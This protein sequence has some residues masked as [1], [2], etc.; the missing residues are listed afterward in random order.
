ML[1]PD[2]RL[3]PDIPRASRTC[4]AAKPSHP[5]G[6]TS[7]LCS[8]LLHKFPGSTPASS[9]TRS[10]RPRSASGTAR[11]TVE[12]GWSRAVLVHRIERDLYRRQGKATTNFVKSLPST[13]S[14]LAHEI[15]T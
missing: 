14:E 3:I 6:L 9:S 10:S 15:L 8:R 5:P 4:R 13:R 12:N 1:T 2:G 7:R 11:V